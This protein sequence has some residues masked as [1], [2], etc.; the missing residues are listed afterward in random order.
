MIINLILNLILIKQ[1]LHVGLAIATSI[2]AWIN[3]ILLFYTL[4]KKLKFQYEKTIITDFIKV[5][6]CSVLMGIIVVS[7][8]GLLNIDFTV[9]NFFGK[10]SLL[11]ILI[12]IFG[13]FAYLLISYGFGIRYINLKKWKK[14]N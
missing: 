2:S 13:G 12:I 7:L 9:L 5:L 14:R 3:V 8:K 11:L 6:F 1:F 10:N 4:K